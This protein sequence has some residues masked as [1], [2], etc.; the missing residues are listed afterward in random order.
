MQAKKSS[1]KKLDWAYKWMCNHIQRVQKSG[2]NG[3][4]Q[5]FSSRFAMGRI[6]QHIH[7][8]YK[9]RIFTL[10]FDFLKLKIDIW[11]FDIIKWLFL[12]A[13]LKNVKYI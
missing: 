12:F 11:I 7:L 13:N 3:F 10:F 2:S 1:V 5:D 6:M 9:Y 8:M 4:E